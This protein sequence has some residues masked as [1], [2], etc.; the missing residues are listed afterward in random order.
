[1]CCIVVFFK[2]G[3][4]IEFIKIL[5]PVCYFIYGKYE[6]DGTCVSK[7]NLV[8]SIFKND[9]SLLFEFYIFNLNKNN[10]I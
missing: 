4:N 7:A 5:N 8:L 9:L 10:N 3:K 1:M 6:N 2:F